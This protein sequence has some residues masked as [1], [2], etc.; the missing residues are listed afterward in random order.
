MNKIIVVRSHYP[1]FRIEKEIEALI[2]G[3]YEVTLLAWDRGRYDKNI[4]NKNI[5]KLRKL[6]LKVPAGNVKVILY[7]PLW[8]FFVIINLIIMK[9]D[10]VH[11][12]DFDSFLPSFLVA[13]FKRVPIVYDILDF[14]ADTIAFPIAPG[15]MR[16]VVSS[17][18]RYLMKFANFIIIVD[19]S[20]KEQIAKKDD[21]NVVVMNNSPKITT[22]NN[23]S[24]E[25]NKRSKFR[26]FFGGGISPDRHI[27]TLILAMRDLEDVELLIMGYCDPHTYEEEIRKLVSNTNNIELF[28]QTVP[29]EKII[30]ETMNSDLLFALYDKNATPNNKYSSPNKLFEAMMSKKPIIVSEGTSMAKIV[31][32]ENC[33]LVVPCDSISSIKSA[34]LKLKNDLELRKE[35]GDNGRKAYDTKYSWDIMSARLINLYMSILS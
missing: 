6:S 21:K 28:L 13:K 1:D 27:D 2:E 16:K 14:Y 9:Y 12:V 23:I 7:L 29:Y 18:D 20:R 5:Y 35:M 26:I 3:G 34:I 11:A 24:L 19:E 33:G 4:I 31:E 15:I 8:C 17:L 22:L 30:R 25:E 10:A 32:E